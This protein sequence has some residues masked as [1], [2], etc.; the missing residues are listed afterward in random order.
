MITVSKKV[1]YSIVFIS[2]L[3]HNK[4]KNVSL[5]EAA[6]K[7]RL[8]Y[9]FLGQ[10]AVILKNGGIIESQEG[11]NGG[12]QLVKGWN[13]KNFYDLLETLGENKPM[14]TCL[15]DKGCVRSKSCSLK[16][17]WGRMERSW[18]LELKKVKLSEI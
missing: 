1:E 11:K 3:S 16:K 7:L 5:S 10:L 6:K 2:F 17:I 4:G 12:Y 13:K 9:R 14:V 8:P 15:G 18:Y